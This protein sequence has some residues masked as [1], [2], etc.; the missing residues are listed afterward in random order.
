MV[1][2]EHHLLPCNLKK[3]C[4]LDPFAVAAAVVTKITDS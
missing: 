3:L 2:K 1:I 4:L